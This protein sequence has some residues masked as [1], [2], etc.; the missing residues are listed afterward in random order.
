MRCF[1]SGPLGREI[2]VYFIHPSGDLSSPGISSGVLL[3]AP[4]RSHPKSFF[5][6]VFNLP[7][8][9]RANKHNVVFKRLRDVNDVT[10]RRRWSRRGRAA[11]FYFSPLPPGWFLFLFSFL[12]N[13]L[14]VLT[15]NLK[16]KKKRLSSFSS[17]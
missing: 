9:T 3:T 10:S 7:S 17:S 16:T 13:R 8:Y 15:K 2:A 12:T 4:L 6:L 5:L 1:P 11:G 14:C